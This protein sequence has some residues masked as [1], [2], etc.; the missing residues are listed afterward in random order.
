VITRLCFRVK[1]SKIAARTLGGPE[2]ERAIYFPDLRFIRNQLL[3]ER[4]HALN[5]IAGS[6][7]P[8]TELVH[9]Q[10]ALLAEREQR[11]HACDPEED[12]IRNHQL[13]NPGLLMV[14]VHIEGE[15]PILNIATVVPV[16]RIR[17]E[18]VCIRNNGSESRDKGTH[19][20]NM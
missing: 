13:L 20:R 6:R 19:D 1:Q 14:R 16:A 3:L 7:V 2:E 5:S 10:F 8:L 18:G 4:F 15:D 17:N 11:N 12:E 9:Q